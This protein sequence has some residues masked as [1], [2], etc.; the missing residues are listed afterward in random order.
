L[1]RRR[2]LDWKDLAVR[3]MIR[4]EYAG[5]HPRPRAK[6]AEVADHIDYVRDVAGTE[7]V[8]I[9]A[10]YDGTDCL[11]EGLEDV[12]CY[13]ALI[14]ELLTRGWSHDD[15]IGLIGGNVLRVLREAESFSRAGYS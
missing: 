15:C 12:S 7:H 2:K 11:P 1:V 4:N 14:A 13:P 5:D 3:A 8:G 6:L 9:G 10:D